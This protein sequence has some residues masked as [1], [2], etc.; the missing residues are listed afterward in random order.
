[1]N[2]IKLMAEKSKNIKENKIPTIAFLGDSITQG[3][4]ELYMKSKHD[5]ETEFDERY[6]YH[7]CIRKIF[8]FLFPNV[9]INIINAG[10]SGGNSGGGLERL[11][12]DVLQYGPDLTIVCFGMNDFWNG[13]SGIEEYG[14]NLKKIFLKLKENGSEVIFMTPNMMNT[15]VSFRLD[16]KEFIDIAEGTMKGQNEGMLE[17]YLKKAETIA[18]EC[19]VRICDVYSKWKR[20]AELGVDTTELLANY[21]NHPKREMHWMFAY[22]LTE[23]MMGE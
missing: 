4:F 17:K 9:P 21:I 7:N 2:I 10:I 13:E 3:C 12:R 6:A 18:E 1:M 23:T 15:Y 20:M 14:G 5:Y 19:G 16:N 22:S 11:E 8:G